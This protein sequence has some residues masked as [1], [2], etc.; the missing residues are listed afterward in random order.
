MIPEIKEIDK[1]TVRLDISFLFSWLFFKLNFI[2]PKKRPVK[3]MRAVEE[4]NI[5]MVIFDVGIICLKYITK[6]VR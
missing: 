2:Y 1:P 6:K 5:P 4:I 3:P